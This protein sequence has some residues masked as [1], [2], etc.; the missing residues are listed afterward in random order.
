MKEEG[1]GAMTVHVV[2]ATE[3]RRMLGSVFSRARYGDERFVIEQR[4][5]PIAAIIGIE[6]LR[7]LERLEAQVDQAVLEYARE[8]A[9]GVVPFG[10]VLDLYS[11]LYGEELQLGDMSNGLLPAGGSKGG[12]LAAKHEAVL[13]GLPEDHDQAL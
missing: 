1:T 5:E 11:E 8:T 4:G 10:E 6:D 2:G 7:R 13:Q 3:V 9:E 12:S